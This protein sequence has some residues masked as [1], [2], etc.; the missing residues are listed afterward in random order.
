[1][2]G[3]ILCQVLFLS[4]DNIARAFLFF[5]E[6]FPIQFAYLVQ[7]TLVPLSKMSGM[8]PRA[9]ME[10]MPGPSVTQKPARWFAP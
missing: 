5:K 1:M 9:T 8:A 3:I 10:R 6:K 2:P 4:K 7:L